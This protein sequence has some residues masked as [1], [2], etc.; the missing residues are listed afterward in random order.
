MQLR[1]F[2]LQKFGLY[3]RDC[4]RKLGLGE[5][6]IRVGTNRPGEN[7]RLVSAVNAFFSS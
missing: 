2:L 1:D 5:K 6:F 4:S 7:E 3:V